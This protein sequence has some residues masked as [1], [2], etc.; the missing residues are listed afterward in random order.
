[1]QP[2]ESFYQRENSAKV[3]PKIGQMFPA[4][5]IQGGEF[6]QNTPP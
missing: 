6:L 5:C 4:I 2:P 3:P 1:M